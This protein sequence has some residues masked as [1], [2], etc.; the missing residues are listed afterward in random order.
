LQ[1]RQAL[2]PVNG[3]GP[4]GED[5]FYTLPSGQVVNGTRPY[6]VTSGRLLN[7]GLLDIGDIQ[8]IATLANSDYNALQFTVEKKVGALRML[9]AY[10]WSKSMDDSSGFTDA[11][12]NPYNNALSRSLSAFD[13]ANNFVV[14]YTY[15]LPFQKLARSTSGPVHKLLDGWEL[16]GITRFAT[17]LPV[18]I[19][20]SGDHSLDGDYYD[21]AIDMPNYNAQPIQFFN[22]RASA[23]YQ[24][25]STSQFSTPDLGLLGTS[26][27]RF[28]HG[29]GLNNWD[30]ALHKMTRVNERTSVEFRAELFNTFNHA[31]FLNPVG[32]FNNSSAFGDV[33]A[34]RDPRIGQFAVKFNF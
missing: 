16:S 9:A 6:S 30:L 31:Q 13:M 26:N 1:V 14:S 7:Q 15:E 33:T 11:E 23:N 20:E 3:C 17:G 34:A 5:E 10:T 28:F 32:D 12:T 18:L 21:N 19:T 29:P 24:Y 8:Y 27:R 25:M 2:G 22:P 4:Y